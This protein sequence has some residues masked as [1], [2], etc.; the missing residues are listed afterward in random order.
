MASHEGA[1][2]A[3]VAPLR[4]LIIDNDAARARQVEEGLASD[5]IVHSATQVHGRVLLDLIAKIGPDVIIM[6]CNSPDRDTIESLRQVAQSNPKPIVMFV[7]DEGL[8]S[9]QEAIAAGVS[10]YVIDG[11]T[12]K[13]VRPLIETAIAR[14]KVMDTMRSE[15]KKTKD[16][17]ASRKAIERAKG[18][19]MERQGMTENQAFSAMRDM[20]Q[21]QGKPLKDVAESVITIFGIIGNANDRDTK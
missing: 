3:A 19:L 21:Q 4:V 14:F 15:L 8:A 18:L 9:M 7:E 13:R 1:G 2:G 12:P 16:D 20:S 11:L 6:D 17:L 10:A 5:A